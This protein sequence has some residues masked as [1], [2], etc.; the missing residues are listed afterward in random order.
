MTEQSEI[1]ADVNEQADPFSDLSSLQL[2][3]DFHAQVGVKK[4]LV[5][6]P[7]RKPHRQEFIRVRD[8]AEYRLETGV[9]ELKEDREYYLLAPEVREQL[10]G[11]WA[12]VRL[13]TAITRQGVVF[14]WPLKLPDPD[15]R[16]NSWHETALNAANLATGQWVK[17]V[18]DMNLGGYQPYLATGELP[19]PD[20]PEHDFQRLLAVAFRERFIR[21]MEHPVITRLL[22][23]E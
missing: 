3:Q 1:I 5:R 12:P 7:V 8:D 19:E 13:V 11:D 14:L 18:A 9:L 23:Y 6:V 20:W 22:G 2:S 10:P 17:L 16:A 21:D 15:G 4:A